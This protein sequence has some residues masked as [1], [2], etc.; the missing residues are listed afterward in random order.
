MKRISH[1]KRKLHKTL[2]IDGF[3]RPFPGE[4]FR[5]LIQGPAAVDGD[6]QFS[7]ERDI[8]F[9]MPGGIGNQVQSLDPCKIVGKAAVVITDFC[10]SEGDVSESHMA[11]EII[12]E[13]FCPFDFKKKDIPVIISVI[14]RITVV[15]SPQDIT[16]TR[17]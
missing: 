11:V 16:R 14:E 9:P 6:L 17:S 2:R 8:V 3:Q 4:G 7:G 10:L 12:P 1:F 5:G 13:P 15:G